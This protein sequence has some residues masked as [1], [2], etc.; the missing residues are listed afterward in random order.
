MLCSSDVA[1]VN[2]A[3]QVYHPDE[4]SETLLLINPSLGSYDHN[5]DDKSI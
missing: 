2:F 4:S 3:L 1:D 5:P